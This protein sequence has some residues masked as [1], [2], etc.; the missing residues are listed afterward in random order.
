MNLIDVYLHKTSGI[1]PNIDISEHISNLSWRIDQIAICA[2]HQ[3]ENIEHLAGSLIL[4]SSNIMYICYQVQY[5]LLFIHA[6]QRETIYVSS[7]VSN[8]CVDLD[9]LYIGRIDFVV[10]N[11]YFSNL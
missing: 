2:S 1:Y 5:S 4:S 9:L 7:F 11:F 6:G 10:I 3:Y 8:P